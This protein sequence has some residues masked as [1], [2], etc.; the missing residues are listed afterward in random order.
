MPLSGFG[1]PAW[2]EGPTNRRLNPHRIWTSSTEGRKRK[3]TQPV[4]TCGLRRN[5]VGGRRLETHHSPAPTD[6]GSMIGWGRN[7]AQ[8]RW[9]AHNGRRAARS[10][11]RRRAQS[12]TQQADLVMPQELVEDLPH[13]SREDGL[14]LLEQDRRRDAWLTEHGIDKAD[15]PAFYALAVASRRAHG[16]RRRL[17]VTDSE[18]TKLRGRGSSA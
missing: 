9:A 16:M 6:Q 1:E 2:A 17:I 13:R 12:E 18:S 7:A 14:V 8:S 10:V 5:D 4:A 11:A 3:I 15:W